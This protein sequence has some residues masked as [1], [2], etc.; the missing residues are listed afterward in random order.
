MPAAI[1]LHEFLGELGMLLANVEP[2]CDRL[3]A[4]LL[5]WRLLLW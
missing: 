5:L 1:V 3:L 4:R 2:D